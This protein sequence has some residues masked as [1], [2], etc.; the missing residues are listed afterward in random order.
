MMSGLAQ[1]QHV[2]GDL[3]GARLGF[4][5]V[6]PFKRRFPD[7][8]TGMWSIGTPRPKLIDAAQPIRSSYSGRSIMPPVAPD[9]TCRTLQPHFSHVHPPHSVSCMDAGLRIMGIGAP[10]RGHGP[11]NIPKP[12]FPL[13]RV[14]T[15]IK[16]TPAVSTAPITQARTSIAPSDS[17][18][19]LRRL[20]RFPDCGRHLASGKLRHG[21]LCGAAA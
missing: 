1:L 10:Q 9:R 19:P 18:S 16:M 20:L 6:G 15:K 5:R 12:H 8:A 13:V 14:C 21:Y 4:V 2:E 3:D 7:G 17:F 11:R